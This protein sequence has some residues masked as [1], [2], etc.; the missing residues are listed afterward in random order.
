ME[1]DLALRREQSQLSF[2]H[3]AMGSGIALTGPPRSLAEAR[4]AA[5]NKGQTDFF[6]GIL[7]AKCELIADISEYL[8]NLSTYCLRSTPQARPVR[9]FFERD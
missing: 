3:H 8:S 4:A 5:K 6:F 2:L 7:S 9:Y 1:A